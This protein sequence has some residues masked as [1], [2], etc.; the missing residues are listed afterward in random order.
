ML[1]NLTPHTVTID[2][3]GTT[4]RIPQGGRPARCTTAAG[5]TEAVE[6]DGHQIPLIDNRDQT[7]VHLPEPTPG[8]FYIVSRKVATAMKGKRDDLL[9]VDQLIIDKTRHVRGC[10]ALARAS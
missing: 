4:V 3:D 6:F 9:I 10:R 7:V 1:I 8:T 2:V 5:T